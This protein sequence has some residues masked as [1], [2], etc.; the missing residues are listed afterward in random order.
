[1]REAGSGSPHEAGSGSP[2][3]RGPRP[4]PRPAEAG[5]PA[6]APRGEGWGGEGETGPCAWDRAVPAQPRRLRGSF[7]PSF[8]LGDSAEPDGKCAACACGCS[9]VFGA[10]VRPRR[11]AVFFSS[12]P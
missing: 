10:A 11:A 5:L 3:A 9:L 4:A 7:F 2:H 6:R 12:L 1:M 8:L